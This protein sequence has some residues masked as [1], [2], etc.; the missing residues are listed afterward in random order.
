MKW[1]FLISL[2]CLCTVSN[3]GPNRHHTW[4]MLCLIIDLRWP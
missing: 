4:R 1:H 2:S 3:K